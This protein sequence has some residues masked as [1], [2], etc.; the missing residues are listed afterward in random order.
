MRFAADCMLGTLAK[1]LLILGHDVTYVRD[2]E[3]AALVAL[4]ARE[5]RTIL[6]C[7]RRLV[8]RR[9]A[10]DHVLVRS[11]DLEEQLAQVLRERGL[12]VRRARLL[13]R[14]LRCNAPTD[15]VQ[16]D[17]VRGRVPVYV[18]RTQIRFTRCPRCG[19]LFWRASHVTRMLERLATLA[20]REAPDRDTRPR[21]RVTPPPARTEKPHPASRRSAPR[22]SATR[23]AAE[24]AS[25]SRA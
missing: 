14:C 10:S 16:R 19:R 7:D 25:R 11:H 20:R 3:D 6:T 15:P 9:G 22:R 1:W 4:A 5:K 21:A 17:E 23:N 13:G 18:F 8:L 12:S 2:I 24:R